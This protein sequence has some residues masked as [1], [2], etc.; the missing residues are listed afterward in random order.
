MHLFSFTLWKLSIY[1]IQITEKT[2]TQADLLQ[3][4]WVRGGDGRGDQLP[5][6]VDELVVQQ[7]RGVSPLL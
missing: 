4:G 1:D 5:V 2:V 6:V 3:T 7:R